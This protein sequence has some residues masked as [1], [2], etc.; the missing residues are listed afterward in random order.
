MSVDLTMQTHF[1]KI[2]GLRSDNAHVDWKSFLTVSVDPTVVTQTGKSADDAQ[3]T[4][5]C[6]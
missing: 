2:S 4:H 6:K 5:L 1:I 3:K